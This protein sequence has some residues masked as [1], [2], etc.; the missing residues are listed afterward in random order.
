MHWQRNV[1]CERTELAVAH[2]FA[3][4]GPTP[5]TNYDNETT[6][7]DRPGSGFQPRLQTASNVQ[8]NTAGFNGFNVQ[9]NTTC[10][11]QH[12]DITQPMCTRACELMRV[13]VACVPVC[14]CDACC[15]Q[16]SVGA[17]SRSDTILEQTPWA[18]H[19]HNCDIAQVVKGCVGTTLRRQPRAGP[20]PWPGRATGTTPLPSVLGDLGPGQARQQG[21]KE[22]DRAMGPKR[23]R[24]RESERE[25]G[26]G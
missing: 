12:L 1:C 11:T 5:P 26:A 14:A 18:Q 22:I 8:V 2:C 21:Q 15:A 20:R 6:R 25:R 23:E 10:E 13:C 4:P 19:A 17:P 16:V 9:R 24:G 7:T 3:C